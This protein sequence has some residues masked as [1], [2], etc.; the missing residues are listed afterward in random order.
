MS[1]LE[2]VN[3]VPVVSGD[4]NTSPTSPSKG[5]RVGPGSPSSSGAAA[6][7]ASHMYTISHATVSAPLDYSFQEIKSMS[8][9]PEHEPSQGKKAPHVSTMQAALTSPTSKGDA[10]QQKASSPT[11]A[12]G[13]VGGRKHAKSPLTGIRLS[14]NELTSLKGFAEALDA[15]LGPE[16]RQNLTWL[17]LS[18]NKLTA[19]EE[20]IT[21]YPNLTH[22]YLHGNLIS[23]IQEV[24]KLS[25]LERLQKLTL[26][27]NPLYQA[28][29]NHGLKNPRSG[30]I[31][32]LRNCVLKSLD[33]VTIT[34][35]D[36]RNALR[37]AEQNNQI[38][39]PRPTGGEEGEGTTQNSR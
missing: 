3:G 12:G 23:S 9:L 20:I 10:G 15:V 16:A 39:R 8:E 31:Y 32:H 13:L 21:T 24:K 27:G 14:Y 2:V 26:H 36:R 33:D 6:A 38:K 11:S 35:A 37:W 17:D 22:L 25:Q 19:I 28:R 7:S 18:H 30:V 5:R 34:N 4:S 1:Q 29:A